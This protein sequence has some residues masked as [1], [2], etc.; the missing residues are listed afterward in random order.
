[1]LEQVSVERIRSELEKILISEFAGNAVRV[2]NEIGILKVILP[3]IIITVGFEQ[4]QYHKHDVFEHTLEVIDRAPRELILRLSALFHDIGKP[5]SLGLGE[6]GNRTFYNHEHISEQIADTVMTRLKF[7]NDQI[8]SVR[9]LVKMHMRPLECGPA[10]VRR[11][12]RDL[13][14]DFDRWR[15]FKMADAPPLTPAHEVQ[16]IMDKF[17]TMVA[18]ELDRKKG[19]VYGT[20]AV[21]GNDL[22]EL[23]LKPGRKLG[24]VLGALGEMVLDNPDLNEKAVLIER[25]RKLINP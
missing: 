6:K 18:A 23:G 2:M 11:L 4:N 1:M 13:G 7:S 17:N 24:E 14:T 16:A 22:I 3:E 10:A 19:S 20:L 8:A 9:R 5:E 21:D 12:M 25:A 15:D